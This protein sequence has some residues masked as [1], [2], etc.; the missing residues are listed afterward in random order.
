[1][2]VNQPKSNS[3][4]L[5]PFHSRPRIRKI[6]FFLGLLGTAGVA[7]DKYY[8]NSAV[9]LRRSLEFLYIFF[10]SSPPFY[11]ESPRI[12][13]WRWRT[14][15]I[16]N[17]NTLLVTFKCGVI[18]RERAALSR[19]RLGDNLLDRNRGNLLDWSG[20]SRREKKEDSKRDRADRF[21][22]KRW[23]FKDAPPFFFS[24]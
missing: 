23:V 20:G 9:T 17:N 12:R 14:S 5:Y 10:F 4:R 22:A 21:F 1:M 18:W 15:S 7:F 3:I 2:N 16:R 11:H 19:E 8:W 24:F 13:R 6:T